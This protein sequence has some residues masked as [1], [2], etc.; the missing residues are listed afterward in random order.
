M[1]EYPISSSSV[2]LNYAFLFFRGQL[3]HEPAFL[4]EYEV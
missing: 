2:N 3:L 4:A 1:M